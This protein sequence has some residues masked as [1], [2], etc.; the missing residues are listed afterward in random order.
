MGDDEAAAIKDLLACSVQCHRSHVP[1]WLE[2]ALAAAKPAAAQEDGST[3]RHS[4]GD[5][6]RGKIAFSSLDNALDPVVVVGGI[7]QDA[8]Y[9]SETAR[10]YVLKALW[11]MHL[12]S[13][14]T[15]L[16]AIAKSN[17]SGSNGTNDSDRPLHVVAVTALAA[18]TTRCG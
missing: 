12:L 7:L 17:G 18:R 6:N 1:A 15:T 3:V 2:W 9:G 14:A 8:K 5:Q 10:L 13:E 11:R 16:A 4:D